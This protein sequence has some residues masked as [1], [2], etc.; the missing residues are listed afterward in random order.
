MR[1]ATWGTRNQNMG[2]G[3][4]K[5]YLESLTTVGFLWRKDGNS[6]RFS[7]IKTLYACRG[8]ELDLSGMSVDG[9]RLEVG[10]CGLF[11]RE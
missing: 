8:R 10:S 6:S 4:K 1:E 7:K 11:L 5:N 3:T 9:A 2:M